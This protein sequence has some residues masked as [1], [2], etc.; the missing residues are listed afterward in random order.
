MRTTEES[1]TNQACTRRRKTSPKCNALLCHKTP[2][3]FITLIYFGLVKHIS[4]PW[5]MI[6]LKRVLKAHTSQK[7]SVALVLLFSGEIW[8]VNP[9]ELN[10]LSHSF[11][12]CC[13]L[14]L[15]VLIDFTVNP[16]FQ[17]YGL[18]STGFPTWNLVFK[19]EDTHH[20]T[21]TLPC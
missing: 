9:P 13:S 8:S 1:S 4:C 19:P 15:G 21:N 11:H 6:S 17:F 3:S 5:L 16:K 7:F 14:S 2:F 20:A 12:V 10:S 18:F